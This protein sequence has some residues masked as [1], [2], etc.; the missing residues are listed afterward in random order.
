MAGVVSDACIGIADDDVGAP[1][2]E[3]AVK[4]RALGGGFVE[5][6]EVEG[7]QGV[8]H[9]TGVS[10]GDHWRLAELFQSV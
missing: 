4:L 5:V 10:G 7:L 9:Q 1:G 2:K 8:G 6:G 3:H